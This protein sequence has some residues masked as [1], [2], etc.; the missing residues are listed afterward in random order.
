MLFDRLEKEAHHRNCITEIS[1]LRPDPL[2]IASRF[3]DEYSALV[4]A[5]FSY[6][7]VNAIVHFLEQIDFSLLHANEDAIRSHT[8]LYYRFQTTRDV[9]EFLI[10]L[11]RMKREHLCLE[12]LFDMGYRP[13]YDVMQGLK[14]LI[15]AL[16]DV[17]AYRSKGYQFLLSKIPTDHTSSPYKRWHMYLRWM[18]RSD[19]LDFGLWRGVN[20]KDLL[21]PLDVHTFR[22]GQKL[23]LITRKT[24]DFKA[25]LELTEA[26]RRFDP[27]DPVKYDFALYRMGQEKSVGKA[28]DEY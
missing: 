11:Y 12:S 1:S 22:V 9:Q 14:T 5:L 18:V 20:P 15:S 24:Y 10:T 8:K 28:G 6:G 17:N 13:K 27:M 23:G 16:Y 26:L 21:M 4:C 19:C 25:V 7:N 3:K 2:L